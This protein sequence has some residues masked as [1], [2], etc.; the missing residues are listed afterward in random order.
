MYS[1]VYN[2]TNQPWVQARENE[3][4]CIEQFDCFCAI[5]ARIYW[6]GWGGMQNISIQQV[7]KACVLLDNARSNPLI[8]GRLKYIH[9]DTYPEVHLYI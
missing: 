9:H 5:N 7:K 8:Y 4:L 3:Y 2:K 6:G 1:R